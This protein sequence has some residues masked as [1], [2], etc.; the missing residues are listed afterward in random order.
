MLGEVGRFVRN[1]RPSIIE[2]KNLQ[3]VIYVTGRRGRPHAAGAVFELQR[4]RE[5][6]PASCPQAS[7]FELDGEGEW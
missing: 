3:R 2:R 1:D 4:Q 7:R 6:N 5:S